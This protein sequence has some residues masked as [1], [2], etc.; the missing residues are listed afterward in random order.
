MHSTGPS[1]EITV[2]SARSSEK[3]SNETNPKKQFDIERNFKIGEAPKKSI[4]PRALVPREKKIRS[5]LQLNLSEVRSP[6]ASHGEGRKSFSGN[7]LPNCRNL[8]KG[9]TF[10]QTNVKVIARIRPLN[11]LE[12]VKNINK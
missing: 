8:K 12:T 9:Q 3:S 7:Q 1:K 6:V 11:K 4:P 10:H 5:S 2:N